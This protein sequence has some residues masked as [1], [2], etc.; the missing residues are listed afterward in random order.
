[1][2]IQWHFFS[3]DSRKF[4]TSWS[5]WRRPRCDSSAIGS[6]IY[7]TLISFLVWL[8]VGKAMGKGA[9]LACCKVTLPGFAQRRSPSCEG[10]PSIS[11]GHLLEM[12]LMHVLSVCLQLLRERVRKCYLTEGVNSLQNCKHVVEDYLES[13]KGLGMARLNSGRYDNPPPR[14]PVD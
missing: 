2:L 14:F 9:V 3:T 8:G 5:G 10:A 11:K 13:I 4:G 1:M 7:I 6:A 12:M